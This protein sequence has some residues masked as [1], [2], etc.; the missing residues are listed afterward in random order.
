VLH[1][2]NSVGSDSVKIAGLMDLYNVQGRWGAAARLAWV[3]CIAV[4]FTSVSSDEQL[5]KAATSIVPSPEVWETMASVFDKV[6]HMHI[7]NVTKVSEDNRHPDNKYYYEI[8][9]VGCRQFME[10]LVEQLQCIV[11]KWEI[12]DHII[13]LNSSYSIAAGIE[14]LRNFSTPLISHLYDEEDLSNLRA[15][16]LEYWTKEQ[17]SS[18]VHFAVRG[19][20]RNDLYNSVTEFMSRAGGSFGCQFHSTLEPGVVVLAAKGQPMT[21]AFDPR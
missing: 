20:L 13:G 17:T 16:G 10:S 14:K 4:D 18:F 5:S 15:L 6:W 2:P 11:Q 1:V 9:R 3:R 7:N 12:E 19:F 8:N 21:F